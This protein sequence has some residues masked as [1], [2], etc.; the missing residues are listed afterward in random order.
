MSYKILVIDSN[1]ERLKISIKNLLKYENNLISATNFEDAYNI[2]KSDGTVQA[3]LTDIELDLKINSDKKIYGQQIFEK[4][5][6]LRYEVNIFI[7]TSERHPVNFQT[8]GLVNGYFYT[9]DNDYENIIKKIHSDISLSKNRAPFFEAL[10][11]YANKTKDSWHTPGHDNGNSLKSSDYAKGFYDFIGQNFFSADLSVSVPSLDSLLD[12]K[13][14]IRD[15]QE[16]AARAYSS[17]YTYFSTNGT[18]TANK[19]ILQTLLKPGDAILLDRNCHKSVHYGIIISGAEPIYLIP[20]VNNKYGIFGPVSKKRIIETMDKAIESGKKVKAIILTN[21][22][23]DGLIYDIRNIIEEA[24]KRGIK[25]IIDE[26]WFGYARFHPEFYPCAMAAGADYSTQS[27]HKTMSAFS[28]ASMIHVQDPDFE[29]FK[30]FFVEN[31]YMHTSTS[32]QY[33]MIASLDVARQQMTMEGYTLLSQALQ[34]SDDLRKA[35]N[36]LLKFKVLELDDLISDEVK[37]DKIR[38]DRTKITIDCSNSGYSGQEIERILN[39]KHNIQVEKTT[40]NTITLLI[41]IGANASKLNRLYLALENIERSSGNLS[42]SPIN[43]VW[44][45]SSLRLSPIKFLPRQAFFSDGTLI[46]LRQSEGKISAS[47]IVPYP[48]GIPILV[49]GQLITKEIVERL[50]LY[51]DYNVEIHGLNDGFLEVLTEE[52]EEILSQKGF[53]VNDISKY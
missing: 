3:V 41:T 51:R 14:V 39:T 22:T 35:I 52:E 53:S 10:V 12:P 48:P 49:P 8:G 24:H 45:D 26:A 23:Y 9:E 2:L 47:M 15:A 7:F 32:P 11:E 38:L 42:T 17:R 34:V 40:F 44:S 33:P 20:S 43:D 18:S 29:K 25:A 36:S 13:S 19:I 46:P 37:D 5:L 1:T 50:L 6:K 16:L 27:T 4:I 31:I 21:C 28:Q 30:D